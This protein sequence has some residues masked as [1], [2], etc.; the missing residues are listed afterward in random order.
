MGEGNKPVV[1]LLIAA[2]L[3]VALAG[4]GCGSE[5]I[6]LNAAQAR[7]LIVQQ[8]PQADP[9]VIAVTMDGDR[10]SAQTEFNGELVDFIFVHDGAGWYLESVSLRGQVFFIEDLEHISTTM[11]LMSELATAL[12]EY[13]ADHG[14]YP[15]GEGPEAREMMVPDYLAE[16]TEVEDAWGN[17]F[18]YFSEDGD[19]Y[20]LVSFG[21]DMEAG[22]RD[23]LILLSGEFITPAEQA[24]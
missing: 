9:R 7:G 3:L 15:V 24:P 10:A 4:A 6:E 13:H 16:D 22:T 1:R 12:A 2:S 23:D 18:T 19:D 21:P 5:P 17:R 8:F 20:T 11:V 14:G